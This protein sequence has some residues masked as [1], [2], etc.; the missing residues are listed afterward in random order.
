MQN[1]PIFL[2][3]YGRIHVSKGPKLICEVYIIWFYI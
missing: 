2:E 1:T 3:Y